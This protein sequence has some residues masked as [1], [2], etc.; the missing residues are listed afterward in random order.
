MTENK[1]CKA[2]VIPQKILDE[3]KFIKECADKGVNY[4]IIRKRQTSQT[5]A[6]NLALNTQDAEMVEQKKLTIQ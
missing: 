4:I 2:E 6:R 1:N 5:L 3:A